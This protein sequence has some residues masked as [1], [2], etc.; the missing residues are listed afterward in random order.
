LDSANHLLEIEKKAFIFG[1][2]FAGGTTTSG[3]VLDF[4]WPPLPG[5]GPQPIGPLFWF[6]IFWETAKIRIFR[7]LE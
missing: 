3:S 2:G 5:P 1:L 6:K 7:L 4:F